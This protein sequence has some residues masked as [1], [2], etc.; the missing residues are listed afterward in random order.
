MYHNPVVSDFGFSRFV[1]IVNM[2]S[3]EVARSDTYCGT[4]S[5][6][7]PEVLKHIPY[8]PMKGDIW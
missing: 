2:N 4:T 5:Y 1:K 6:N 8:D 3:G 7:P